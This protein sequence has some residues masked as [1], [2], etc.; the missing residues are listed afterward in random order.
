MFGWHATWLW[1][2]GYENPPMFYMVI[3]GSF[4]NSEHPV[5]AE[6]L[7]YCVWGDGENVS[8]GELL[9]VPVIKIEGRAWGSE[10]CFYGVSAKCGAM[11]G[12]NVNIKMA[13]FVTCWFYW[14]K[15]VEAAGVEPVY[16]GKL[17]IPIISLMPWIIQYSIF[18]LLLISLKITWL[19]VSGGT[20]VGQLKIK[21]TSFFR[22]KSHGMD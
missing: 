16:M 20:M 9:S 21:N 11:K 2:W 6:W 3:I 5:E 13:Y 18:Q 7:K 4:S 1:S 19:P 10:C 8:F 22:G 17:V 15:M 14:I 12:Q